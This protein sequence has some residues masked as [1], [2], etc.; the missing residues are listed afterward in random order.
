MLIE[1]TCDSKS[2]T[3]EWATRSSLPV[4]W[5]HTET[6]GRFMFTW[7][8]CEISYWSEILAPVQELGWTHARVTR[9]GMAFCG[10]IM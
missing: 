8:R 9:A 10:G 5:F 6:D 1:Y 3:F 7:Y 4:D 2:Q